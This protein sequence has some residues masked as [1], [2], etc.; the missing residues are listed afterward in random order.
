[1]RIRQNGVI[2]V[3]EVQLCHH[4]QRLLHERVLI[5]YYG[6][7]ANK[8]HGHIHEVVIREYVSGLVVFHINIRQQVIIP[9]IIYLAMD[10]IIV[11]SLVLWEVNHIHQEQHLHDMRLHCLHVQ[12]NVVIM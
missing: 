2:I 12:S 1:M 9:Q 7:Q 8:N 4:D 11:I 6:D 10:L 5:K 3:V